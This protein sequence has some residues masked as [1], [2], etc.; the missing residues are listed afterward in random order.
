MINLAFFNLNLIGL[1]F[2]DLK[3][4]INQIAHHLHAQTVG[5]FG[6]NLAAIGEHD[7]GEALVHVCAGDNLTIHN[8][9]CF[10]QM[11]VNLAK[12]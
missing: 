3:Q 7:Q 2:L 5:F 8:R 4:L 9:G 6:A 11:G 10:A 1:G 12:G